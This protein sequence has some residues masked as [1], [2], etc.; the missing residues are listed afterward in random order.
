MIS[1]HSPNTLGP[2]WVTSAKQ[3]VLSGNTNEEV[4]DPTTVDSV[5]FDVNILF[6]FVETFG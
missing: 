5:M 6:L 4:I 1:A 2:I 3:T